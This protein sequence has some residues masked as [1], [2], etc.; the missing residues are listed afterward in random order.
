MRIVAISEE[1]TEMV[2]IADVDLEVLRRTRYNGTVT[3]LKDR[4]RDLYEIKFNHISD[5]EVILEMEEKS[6]TE[7]EDLE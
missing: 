6:L 7:P 4:R 2:V 1:N 5:D 3:P